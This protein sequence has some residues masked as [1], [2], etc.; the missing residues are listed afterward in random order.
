MLGTVCVEAVSEREMSR[1]VGE[2]SSVRPR[3][4]GTYFK[5]TLKL[6]V[7][8]LRVPRAKARDIESALNF[9]VMVL[10]MYVAGCCPGSQ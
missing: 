3:D 1:D 8:Y 5:R 2:G 7:K 10:M 4:P 6:G 9:I